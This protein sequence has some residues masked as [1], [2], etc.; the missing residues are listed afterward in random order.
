[1]SVHDPKERGWCKNA[2]ERGITVTIGST[3]E[4]YLDAFPMPHEFVG[5]LMTGQY[6]LVEVYYLTTRYLSW[7]MVLFGDPLYNPW[8]AQP[9]IKPDQ[10]AL[11]QRTHLGSQAPL[12]PADRPHRDPLTQ[13]VLFHKAQGQRLE[14]VERLLADFDRQLDKI[15]PPGQH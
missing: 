12:P 15:A 10:V 5:L 14:Q 8:H 11:R 1:M 3:G 13:R 7:R 2:L 6:S 9:S 4:P